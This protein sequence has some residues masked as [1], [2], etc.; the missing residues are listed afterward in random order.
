MN[1]YQ[2]IFEHL[3]FNKFLTGSDLSEKFGD[4]GEDVMHQLI[5]HDLVK[6]YA[7]LTRN[8]ILYAETFQHSA[9]RARLIKLAQANGAA[10]EEVFEDIRR[11][12]AAA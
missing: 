11:I 2:K 4:F 7:D 8:D 3:E 1:I 9:L 5:D 10:V 6:F 12:K